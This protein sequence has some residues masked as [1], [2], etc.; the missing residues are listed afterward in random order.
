MCHFL[1]YSS[2]FYI[3]IYIT[4][5]CTEC[6]FCILD[7]HAIFV[8]SFIDAFK[9]LKK[10]H[11]EPVE[12]MKTFWWQQQVQQCVSPIPRSGCAARCAT[13]CS[14]LYSIKHE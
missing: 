8:F 11:P 4:L 14:R 2:D 10:I 13:M 1:L 3:Y 12:V 9:R 6:L 7:D 5:N